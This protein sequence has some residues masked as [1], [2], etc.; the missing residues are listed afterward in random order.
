MDS[1]Q[2]AGIV[3]ALAAAL[4]GFLVGQGYLDDSTMQQL[5]GA[6]TTIGVAVWSVVAKRNA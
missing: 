4:G 5:V 2:I 3:R 1:A 6:V